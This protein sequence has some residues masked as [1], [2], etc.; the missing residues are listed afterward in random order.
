MH[1]WNIIK[2]KV[3][4]P[5]GRFQT[6]LIPIQKWIKKFLEASSVSLPIITML[7]PL[8]GYLV[9][10]PLLIVDGTKLGFIV[11]CIFYSPDF[12]RL[13]II[14]RR[15]GLSFSRYYFNDDFL[16]FS[17]FYSTYLPKK[18]TSNLFWFV[19]HGCV[20][21]YFWLKK[22]HNF[23]FKIAFRLLHRLWNRVNSRVTS[24]IPADTK[25]FLV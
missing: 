23:L 8:L 24:L 3:A 7:L 16:S 20:I 19:T 4:T 9:R 1:S 22:L 13:P 2:N 14:S 6:Y 15:G 17:L 21:I 5:Y 18:D 11:R 12:L 25:Y 10:F